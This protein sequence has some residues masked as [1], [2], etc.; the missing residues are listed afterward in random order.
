MLIFFDIDG[1]LIGKDSG[2]IPESARNAIQKARA[3]GHICMIN[4]GRSRKLVGTDLTG[5]TE[6]DGLAL[7]CGTMIV[8]RGEVL[9]HKS[10]SGEEGRQ[11]IE[12]LRRNKIDA[13]LEGSEDNFCERDD[14]IV[15]N[16]FRRFIHRFDHLCYRPME[17]AVGHF[18]KLYAYADRTEKMEAFR[19]EFGE[20]LDFVDRKE[21]YFE[22]MPKGYSKASAMEFMARRLSIPMSQVAAVGDSSNDLSMLKC[23]GISIAM[24][25]ATEDVKE[26]ADFV[27][28]D[29]EHN[30][31]RN[32]LNWLEK[33]VPSSRI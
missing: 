6:F 3:S 14:R 26:M 22:I 11:I 30:G 4:T 10:F 5:Q 13:C 18:D 28:T 25:N 29:V 15:T 20:L 31:I 8:Y 24:G 21:G 12:G 17:E 16:V 2:I 33:T 7:G 1:T 19:E 9:L 32:A 23:A 27:S